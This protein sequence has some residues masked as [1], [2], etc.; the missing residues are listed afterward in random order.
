VIG[1][2]SVERP[3]LL[4]G[5]LLAAISGL[6]ESAAA[7]TPLP[8]ANWQYSTGVVLA[9]LAGPVPEW[10][11]TFGPGASIEPRFP[12]AKRYEFQPSGIID[13][14]YR[15]IAFVSDGEGIGVDLLHGRGYRAGIAVS[16]DL[17]RNSHD[18]PRLHN[19]RNVAP[20][21]E[22][23]LFAQYFLL[24]VVLTADVRKA[25]GGHEGVIGDLG[26][27]VPLPLGDHSFFFVGPSLTMADRRYMQSYF[28]VSPADAASSGL[29]PFTAQGGFGNATLAGSAVFLFGDHWL[30]D[31]DGAYERLLGDEVKSPITET[32]NQFLLSLNVGYRF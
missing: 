10:R 32:R 12:G 26:A 2:I 14:R 5:A 13:I 1:I 22:P 11:V 23:K 6:V 21:P 29:R 31:V 16:Y 4:A 15:D 28:G 25:I 27:Y 17:G 8:L 30:L 19:L 7:Q 18:D 9:P 3:V 24:P 20:A